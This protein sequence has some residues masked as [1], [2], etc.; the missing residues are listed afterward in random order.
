ML[1]KNLWLRKELRRQG[2]DSLDGMSGGP[3][4]PSALDLEILCNLF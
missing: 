3:A 1:G 2:S 4:L